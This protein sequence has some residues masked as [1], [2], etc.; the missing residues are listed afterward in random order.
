MPPTL[1]SAKLSWPVT[2]VS[3]PT[4]NPEPDITFEMLPADV[5]NMFNNDAFPDTNKLYGSTN[6]GDSSI[7]CTDP[8]W[9]EYWQ[10][11]GTYNQICQTEDSLLAVLQKLYKTINPLQCDCEVIKK[12][13]VQL[14]AEKSRLLESIR[15]HAILSERLKQRVVSLETALRNI[16][17]QIQ[18]SYPVDILRKRGLSS[19]DDFTWLQWERLYPELDSSVQKIITE[20]RECNLQLHGPKNID[21][22]IDLLKSNLETVRVKSMHYDEKYNELRVKLHKAG[23]VI[24]ALVNQL[25]E[26]GYSVRAIDKYLD[27]NGNASVEELFNNPARYKFEAVPAN[28]SAP[29][30]DQEQL[31]KNMDSIAAE[32][33]TL[34]T[35]TRIPGQEYK[36]P[37]PIQDKW[38]DT[39]YTGH[40]ALHQYC[41]PDVNKTRCLQECE[42][43][44]VECTNGEPCSR[45]CSD[46]CYIKS[47]CA[48]T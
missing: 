10:R 8:D 15:E 28:T 27:P 23:D 30:L 33:E 17:R 25:L 20:L 18:R 6:S 37:F 43:V 14:Y 35:K 42:H 32:M 45:L 21:S 24:K 40:L 5:R 11:Q 36:D 34:K 13:V 16:G 22:E 4:P 1:L 29:Y 19:V 26:K 41:D 38:Y 12:H 44:C 39:P 7:I 2:K 9:I 46:V 3:I 31:R 48:S 47:P